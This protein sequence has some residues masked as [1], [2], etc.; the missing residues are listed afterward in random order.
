M[1]HAL[2]LDVV[3]P[4]RY[5]CAGVGVNEARVILECLVLYH[6][7]VL[8]QD[9]GNDANRVS[10]SSSSSNDELLCCHALGW[11]PLYAALW[12]RLG[13]RAVVK[14]RDARTSMAGCCHKGSLTLSMSKL[15]VGVGL[16]I[17]GRAI[18]VV[19]ESRRVPD[20]S[21]DGGRNKL[22]E[23]RPCTLPDNSGVERSHARNAL[24]RKERLCILSH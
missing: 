7:L 8:G 10:S 6:W 14:H 19:L 1:I 16:D 23:Q 22:G 20:T 9:R 3:T 18:L 2:L 24:Q 12:L 11:C 4:R 15:C 5:A 13:L 17:Y 21:G